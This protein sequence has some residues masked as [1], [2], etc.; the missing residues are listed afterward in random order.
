MERAKDSIIQ[1]FL[2]RAAQSTS[3]GCRRGDL[4]AFLAHTMTAKHWTS[5]CFVFSK[6]VRFTDTGEVEGL[7]GLGFKSQPISLSRVSVTIA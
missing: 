7:V 6:L 4:N 3:T 2:Q 5:Q 1:S